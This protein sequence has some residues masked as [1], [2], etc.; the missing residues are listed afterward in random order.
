MSAFD[1]ELER[2]LKEPRRARVPRVIPVAEPG[3]RFSGRLATRDDLLGGFDCP[4]VHL[5]AAEQQVGEDAEV[6]N[7]HH[8]QHPDHL[9]HAAEVPA[10]EDVDEHRDRQPDPDDP[11]KEDQERP[12]HLALTEHCQHR[13]APLVCTLRVGVP[14]GQGKAKT[15][16]DAVWHEA[17]TPARTSP[18][19]HVAKRR[20]GDW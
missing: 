11:E 7:E 12:E 18:K 16:P 14:C 19:R 20:S 17:R 5:P 6:G 10:A 9:A 13:E 15:D 1:F 8:Q 4:L 2:H 3:H